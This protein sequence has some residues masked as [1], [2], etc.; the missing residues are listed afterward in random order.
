MMKIVLPRHA[1]KMNQ[2]EMELRMPEFSGK[3]IVAKTTGKNR[4][5]ASTS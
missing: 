3:K 4:Y 5:V 1:I 2:E